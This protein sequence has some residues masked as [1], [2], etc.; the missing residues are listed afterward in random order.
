MRA[1]SATSSRDAGRAD[2]G[3]GR[4]LPSR[5][6][7]QLE[8]VRQLAGKVLRGVNANVHL[9]GQQ[10]VLHAAD[11]ARLVA[12]LGVGGLHR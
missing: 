10:R 11:E 12:D 7:D 9:A 1:P 8:A 2:V 5:H 6:R 3:V 4:V